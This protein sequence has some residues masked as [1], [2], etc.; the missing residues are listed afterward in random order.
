MI[1][2]QTKRGRFLAALRILISTHRDACQERISV[3]RHDRLWKEYEKQF[4]SFMENYAPKEDL[5]EQVD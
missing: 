3:D 1:D 2:L 4:D 5:D